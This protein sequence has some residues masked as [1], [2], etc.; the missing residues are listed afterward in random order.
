MTRISLLASLGLLAA[1]LMWGFGFVAVKDSLDVMPP[2][3]MIALRFSMATI[4]LSLVFQKKLL[5]ALR[6]RGGRQL[7]VHG[8]YLAIFLFLAYAFQ[9]IGCIYTTA[10]KNAFLTTIYV[11]LV[12]LIGWLLTRRFPGRKVLVAAFIAFVGIGLL[13]LRDDLSVNKGDVLT[14][15]CGLFYALHMFFIARFTQQDDPIVLT[16]IQLFFTATF[17]WVLAPL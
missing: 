17:S 11:I 6:A 14:L 10:G 15:I 8:F 4:L 1:T 3:Y 13:S 7:L 16:L 9:T 5:A 2:I 12:P